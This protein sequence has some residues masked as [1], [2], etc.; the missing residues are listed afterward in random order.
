VDTVGAGRSGPAIPC[1][2]CLVAWLAAQPHP[3][4]ELA[5][6][7]ALAAGALA[8]AEILLEIVDPS[9]GSRPFTVLVYP[10][11]SVARPT[12]A[13]DCSHRVGPFG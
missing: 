10:T 11:V 9:R 6:A 1:G 5:P 3:P 2:D 4:P 12:L 8:S 13:S 7:V